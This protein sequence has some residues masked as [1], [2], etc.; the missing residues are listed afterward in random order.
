M[1]FLNKWYTHTHTHTHTHTLT[2]TQKYYS[3]IKKKEILPKVTWISPQVIMLSE[4]S[5]T[6]KDKYSTAWYHL[7][8]ESKNK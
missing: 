4:K 7:F 3:A 8:V 2:Q 1:D 5:Q 6:E